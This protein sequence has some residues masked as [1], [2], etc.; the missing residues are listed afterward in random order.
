MLVQ[1]LVAELAVEALDVA[2]LH[3]L[4]WLDEQVTD[5]VGPLERRAGPHALWVPKELDG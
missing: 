4:A 1:A 3:R 5:A 2:V